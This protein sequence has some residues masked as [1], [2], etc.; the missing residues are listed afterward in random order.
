MNDIMSGKA[1]KNVVTNQEEEVE[2]QIEEAMPDVL[3]TEVKAEILFRQLLGKSNQS[4]KCQMLFLL[5]K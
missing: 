1:P 3:Q 4:M 5:R 2:Q